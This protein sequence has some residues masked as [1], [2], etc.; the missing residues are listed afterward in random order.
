VAI[1]QHTLNDGTTIP[2]IGF[3]T[4]PL[5]GAPGVAAVR[6]AI[7][8]GYRL[9]DSAFAYDNEGAVGAA[10]RSCGVPRDELVVTSKLPGRFHGHDDAV[11]AVEESV[12]RTGLDRIDLYLIHWP[13]PRRGR[14]VQAWQALI[15]CRERGL[16]RSIGVSNFLP[17]H[18]DV[19]ERE[20]GVVPAV[21]QVE[22]H[23]WLPQA[24]QVAYHEEHGIRTEAWA[25][26]GE[27]SGLRD[28]PVISQIAAAHGVTPTQVI[29][30][31]D[32]ERGVV[33]LPK[34]ASPDRRRENLD[35]FGFG[36]ADDEVAAITALGRG[37]RLFDADPATHEEF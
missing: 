23:P 30:R 5:R 11:A 13:L 16:V 10:I 22:L 4:Y 24:E 37:Q 19:L 7:E 3:G 8:A 18:L 35:V 17:E 20:T 25:P 33:P 2:A 21:N 34:S 36:L 14:Y 27:G 9:I 26:V 6:D 15:E 1:P 29:L 32:V 12:L 31:W 28:E